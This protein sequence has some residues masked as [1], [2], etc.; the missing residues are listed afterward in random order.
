MT[1]RQ[2]NIIFLNAGKI[3]RSK[4]SSSSHHVLIVTIPPIDAN[5]I[6]IFN[7]L[8]FSHAIR[9]FQHVRALI[10]GKR[11]LFQKIMEL[12]I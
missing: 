6:F 10:N 7:L 9:V 5:I 2:I 11:M 1:S 3:S 8:K 12:T 4:E